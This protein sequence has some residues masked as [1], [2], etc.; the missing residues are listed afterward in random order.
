MDDARTPPHTTPTTPPNSD[1]PEDSPTGPGG[2]TLFATF[3]A[4]D[5][6]ALIDYLQ[7]VL[8]FVLTARYDDGER[9]AHA[10]LRRPDDRGGVMLGDV[11][12]GAEWPPEPGGTG[13]YVVADDIDTLYERVV[14]KGAQVITPLA[15]TPYRS[16]E[17]AVR[18]P[19]GNM[20]SFGT[21]AGEQVPAAR[22]PE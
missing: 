18:D 12:K 10:E 1:L 11:Q 17:F 22:A 5:A 9:V 19:E 14:A 16:R 3:R 20:W 15:D 4:R 13:L 7:D 21:Y 6:A 8:G 2:P